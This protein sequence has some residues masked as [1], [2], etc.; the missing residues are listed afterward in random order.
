MHTPGS[1]PPPTAQGGQGGGGD[2]PPNGDEED[3]K[4]GQAGQ[5]GGRKNIK[6]KHVVH[7]AHQR[8]YIPLGHAITEMRKVTSF[9]A[10]RK[11]IKFMR[12]IERGVAMRRC[13]ENNRVHPVSNDTGGQT[14]VRFVMRNSMLDNVHAPICAQVS[15]IGRSEGSVAD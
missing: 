10:P 8:T 5:E 12:T 14:A 2:G 7:T 6:M 4:E 11:L 1:L 9:M 15:L 13:D 3:G